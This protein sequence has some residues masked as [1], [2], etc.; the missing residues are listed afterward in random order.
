MQKISSIRRKLSTQLGFL[1]PSFCVKDNIELPPHQYRILLLGVVMG[2]ADI[3]SD[4][5]LAIN[6]GHISEPIS[7][8]RCQDPTFG[9]AAYWINLEQRESAQQLGYTVV[10]ACTV[11][12][13]HVNHILQ[14]HSA[15]LFGHEEAQHILTK[16]AEI[17]PKLAEAL[18]PHT[19]PLYIFVKILQQLLAENIP[20]IDI[21]SIAESLIE[22]GAKSQ[23]PH[24]LTSMVRIHL[25]NFIIQHICGNSNKFSAV[26]LSPE[27]E[28]LLHQSQQ[29]ASDHNFSLEPGLAE[30]L[31]GSLLAY[32]HEQ[33]TKGEAAILLVSPTI[34]SHLAHLFR[35][36][37]PKL[38]IL[39]YQELP[40]YKEVNIV[41]SIGA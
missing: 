32:E 10:D 41:G 25:K 13:T 22:Y 35:N 21:R 29:L 17:A 34:R 39:S 18:I 8:I 26:T 16:L 19:L 27:L 30:K 24:Y 4:K 23:D 12:G 11:I 15:Q 38:N 1:I 9:L 5:M 6:T 28:Q 20:I 7:G 2:Y 31:H 14:T 33:I 40:S 3:Y 36:S 37:I